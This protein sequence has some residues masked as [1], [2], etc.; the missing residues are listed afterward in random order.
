MIFITTGTQEPFDRLI[1]AIDE[2][3]PSLKNTEIIAQVYKSEFI[4]KH[5]KTFEFLSPKE[6]AFYFNSAELIIA[7][8]GM[9]T[10]ISALQ[11][12][13]PLIILPRL[14]V[15][16]EHRN[17]HQLLT[18][19]K[20][21]DFNFVHVAYDEAE[22]KKKI[23]LFYNNEIKSLHKLGDFGSKSLIESLYNEIN[24]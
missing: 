18:A 9:G 10:I 3:A 21:D 19:K 8:A 13:K 1:K 4:P 14:A 12:E 15:F 20:F 24:N 5:M 2:I 6:F 7:H 22:L 11:I 23:L 17:D 16:H